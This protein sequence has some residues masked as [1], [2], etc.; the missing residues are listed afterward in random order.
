MRFRLQFAT[1][2]SA[3]EGAAR[4]LEIARILRALADKIEAE[5]VE[6]NAHTLLHDCNGNGV[7]SAKLSH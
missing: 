7:G 2:N 5:G 4:P 6:P 3:F 1:T